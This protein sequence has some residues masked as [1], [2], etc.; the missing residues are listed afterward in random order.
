MKS[1]WSGGLSIF[2]L[3]ILVIGYLEVKNP[4]NESFFRIPANLNTTN[5]LDWENHGPKNTSQLISDDPITSDLIFGQSTLSN[6]ELRSFQAWRRFARFTAHDRLLPNASE[7]IEAGVAA[8]RKLMTSVEDEKRETNGSATEK[9][10]K[11]KQCPRYLSDMNASEVHENGFGLRFPCGLTQGSSIT[12]I[13]IPWGNFQVQLIGELLPGEPDPPIILQYNVTLNVDDISE[14]LVIISQNTWTV[15][16]GWGEEEHC[17]SA[18]Q[19]NRTKVD[20]LDRCYKL[21]GDDYNQ[22]I[23]TNQSKNGSTNSSVVYDGRPRKHSPFKQNDLF[24]ATLRIGSEGI[25]MMVDGNHITSFAFHEALE[26]WLVGKI[27]ISG[28]LNVISVVAS[29]LPTSDYLEHTTDISALKPVILTPQTELDLFVG[30]LSTAN[31]LRRRMAVRSSWM[32][33]PAVRS[34]QVAVRFFVGLNKNQTVNKELWDE[35]RTFEDIQLMPF[36]DSYSLIT[37]K[38]IAICIYGTEVV[39]AE[40]IMK[41]D[42]DSFVRVDEVLNSLDRINVTHGLLYGLIYSD[43]EPHREPDSKWY[44]TLEEWP[45]DKYPPWA[46]GPGYVVSKDI[47]EAVSKK[48]R[49]GQLKM[50][51]LE[52]VAVGIWIL[53]MKNKGL[54]VRYEK[55]D[56][57]VYECKDGYVVAHRQSPGEL[58]CLWKKIQEKNL[59]ICCRN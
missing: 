2:L 27:R 52:D 40:F 26:P 45:D 9:G 8:F 23:N 50:F 46:S 35:A 25:H 16:H 41:T 39:S 28:D 24:A 37:W 21:G 30:V 14:E 47:A 20:E 4:I 33:Y 22:T 54:Q 10:W 29:G 17:P 44:T 13:G 5:P 31:N 7:A 18:I 56:R 49:D 58:L 11:E 32:Q 1:W 3:L 34:G 38:T 59:T 53:D 6:E 42:D 55:D 12:F 51:K 48:H 19:E 57:I 15:A 36:I 43:L